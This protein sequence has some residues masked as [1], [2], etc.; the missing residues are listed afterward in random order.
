MISKY[1]G[2]DSDYIIIG[3]CGVLLILFILT[4]VNIVQMK[5]L[6]KELPHFYEWKRCKDTGRYIDSKVR[7]G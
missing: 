7:S 6:K 5:K 4:I 1:L 2:F 3:L